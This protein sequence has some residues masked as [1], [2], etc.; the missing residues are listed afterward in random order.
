[1]CWEILFHLKGQTIQ[2]HQSIIEFGNLKNR[3]TGLVGSQ[4]D[5]ESDFKMRLEVC[6][7]QVGVRDLNYYLDLMGSH[8]NII[9]RIVACSDLNF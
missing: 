1:M 8:Q 3:E 2:R 6:K 9:Y 5:R 4:Q 7:S